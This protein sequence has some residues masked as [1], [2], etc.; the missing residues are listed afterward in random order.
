MLA[1]FLSPLMGSFQLYSSLTVRVTE[2]IMYITVDQL[3]AHLWHG[4]AFCAVSDSYCV[5]HP[6][7]NTVSIVDTEL[8][9]TLT[10]RF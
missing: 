9:A 6:S 10:L 4:T 5:V 3:G 1:D 2:V 7:M 8:A